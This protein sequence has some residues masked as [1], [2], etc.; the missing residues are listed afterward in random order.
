MQQLA[1]QGRSRLR[2]SANSLAEKVSSTDFTSLRSPGAAAEASPGLRPQPPASEDGSESGGED[3]SY[4]SR[5][6]GSFA[7][8][9]GFAAA[10][11][12]EN[13][14]LIKSGSGSSAAAVAG[15]PGGSGN[16]A[17]GSG[18]WSDWAEQ[19]LSRARDAR[20]QGLA[21]AESMGSGLVRRRRLEL[22][23]TVTSG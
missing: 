8:R 15:G 17:T 22:A 10:R 23:G 4:A 12:P 20:D 18:S 16:G 13:E 19:G 7:A 3:T 21:K 11:S 14:S 6:G 1:E 5:F 9:M 2:D